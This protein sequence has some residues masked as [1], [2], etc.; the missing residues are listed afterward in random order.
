MYI[1]NFVI[2]NFR[3]LEDIHCDLSPRMNVFVGPNG[4]GKTTVLQAIRLAKALIA[5]RTQNEATQTLIGLGAGSPHFPQRLFH[6]ALF[7]DLTRHVEIRVTHTISEAEIALIEEKKDIIIQNMVMSQ[8]GQQFMNPAVM[9]QF[10]N[11]P[12]GLKLKVDCGVEFSNLI[13]NMKRVKSF[14]I[15]L[16]IESGTGNIIPFDRTAGNVFSHIDQ[17][18]PPHLSIFSYFPADR[19]LPIGEVAVQLGAADSQQQVESHNSQPQIKYARLKNMIFNT[20]VMG[21]HE[22]ESF[23][24]EFATIFD[25][26]LK[27]RCLQGIGINE[28]GLLSVNT[29]EIE[30]GRITEIDSLSS[31]EKNLILTFLLIAKSVSSGGIVLFD[32][33]ELH[34][35]SAV[36][37]DLLSFMIKEYSVKRNIQFI[38]CTHS[39]EIL[40]GA[41]GNENCS[42]FHVKSATNASKVG[43]HA[44]DEYSDALHQLG[45]SVSETLLYDGALL[46]EGDD[47]VEFLQL[48]FP[49]L[50]KRLLIKDRGGRPEVEKTAKRIQKLE[51]KG[52]KVSPIFIIIDRDDSLTDLKNSQNVRILQWKRRCIDN[53]LIDLEVIAELLKTSEVAAKTVANEG[54]VD[55][56]FRELAF[57]QLDAVATKAVYREAGFLSPSFRTNDFEKDSSLEGMAA[58]I[59]ARLTAAKESLKALDVGDWAADFLERTKAKK[60]AL[61]RFPITMHHTRRR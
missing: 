15:G 5:P 30:S 61:E 20:L 59:F 40:T 11:S 57:E 16:T 23:T 58:A 2:K 31:G 12:F 27:G 48:G 17:S 19:A 37:R 9:I 28:L 24:K 44:V 52:E 14:V 53:Y 55:R 8:S 26:I 22:R 47:D 56:L 7:R 38:I 36:C 42:L 43:R 6:Q 49:D 13:D 10:L 60:I 35:N 29:L 39:P 54:E 33:P 18:L 41:F 25:G 51:S 50:L 34:L 32:E 46:V 3:A 1:S 4:M 21:E 45:T